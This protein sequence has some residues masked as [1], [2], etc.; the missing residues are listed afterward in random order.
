MLDTTGPVITNVDLR[1]DMR[2]RKGF[3]LRISDNLSGI[4]SW[5]GTLDGDWILLEYEPKTKTL[6]HAFDEHSE[7][8]GK[9]EFKL[10]V[11]DER[12]NTSSYRSE[13]TH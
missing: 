7:G 5:R 13:F 9:M 8:A 10:N 6:S 4:S 11:V 3:E 1:A 12:G 2:G